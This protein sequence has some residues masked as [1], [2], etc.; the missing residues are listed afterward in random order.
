[1]AAVK[2]K[3]EELSTNFQ[4]FSRVK[5]ELKAFRAVM[6]EMTCKPVYDAYIY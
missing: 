2:I 3:L 6:Q 5:K 4:C 1:M